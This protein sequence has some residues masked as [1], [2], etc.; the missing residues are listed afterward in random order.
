[1]SPWVMVIVCF[2]GGL[3]LLICYRKEERIFRHIGIFLLLLGV[4]KL[5]DAVTDEALSFSWM[6][7]VK[8]A[9]LL[10]M[11]IYAGVYAW[12][13]WKHPQDEELP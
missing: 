5:M 7:W 9:V 13:R 8:R 10:S 11:I 4:Y 3:L 1:M 12:K 2:A 6:I